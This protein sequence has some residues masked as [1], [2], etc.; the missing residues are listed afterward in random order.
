VIGEVIRR[1]LH[2]ANANGTELARA[3]QRNARLAGMRRRSDVTPIRHAERN[4]SHL[5]STI[6]SASRRAFFAPA[7]GFI[8]ALQLVGREK[9]LGQPR[10]QRPRRWSF[11]GNNVRE[12]AA[13]PGA[14]IHRDPPSYALSLM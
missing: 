14:P 7:T 8:M 2:Q 4:S 12:F 9:S 6:L 3:P 5:H 1:V 10:T 13:S 11:G